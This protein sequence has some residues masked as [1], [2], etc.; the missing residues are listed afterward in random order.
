MSGNGFTNWIDIYSYSLGASNPTTVGTGTGS[1]A[2]KVSMTSMSIQK[3]IDT[4]T[5]SLFLNCCFGQPL[6]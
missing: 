5:P 6:R 2:G 4:A 3:S 1:G